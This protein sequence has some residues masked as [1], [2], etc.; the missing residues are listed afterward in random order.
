MNLS[1]EITEFYN[2]NHIKEI[3]RKGYYGEKLEFYIENLSKINSDKKNLKILDV[4]CND[5]ELT[6]KFEKYGKVLAIDIN[7]DAVKKCR[8]RG[9]DCLCT[10]IYGLPKKYDGYFDVIIAGDIIEHVFD[11][12][13]FLKRLYILLKKDGTLLLTTAN[14]ASIGRRIMLLMGK[15]P[16]TEFST[17]LPNKEFNVGH[18]RYYT[19]ENMREQFNMIGFKNIEIFGDK[20]NLTSKL[21][22]PRAIAKYLPT[23]SRYMHVVGIKP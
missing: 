17:L 21:S 5:G 7:K 10:D 1:N 6:K 23:I 14:I 18:I 11:T 9:I 13:E 8:E 3:S 2:K 16:Y 20:I 15:N 12:D 19:V 22:I 4:A